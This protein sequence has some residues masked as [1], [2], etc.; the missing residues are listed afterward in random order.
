MAPEYAYPLHPV[1]RWWVE[2]HGTGGV[3]VPGL[4][5]VDLSNGVC[6]LETNDLAL[7]EAIERAPRDGSVEPTRLVEAVLQ[8]A[9][10]GDRRAKLP[11]RHRRPSRK[12]QISPGS[13]GGTPSETA[14]TGERSP[15]PPGVLDEA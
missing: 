3:L 13:A 2:Q 9:G 10:F 1:A 5:W 6:E 8:G 11:W 15:T 7:A 14:S 4:L 12:M